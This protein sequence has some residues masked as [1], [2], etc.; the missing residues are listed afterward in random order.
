[1]FQF[2]WFDFYPTY[3][4]DTRFSVYADCFCRQFLLFITS[5]RYPLCIVHRW[6][7]LLWKQFILFTQQ[8]YYA[9][10]PN[11]LL[12]LYSLYPEQWRRTTL[13]VSLTPY[14][15]YFLKI[16]SQTRYTWRVGVFLPCCAV[17]AVLLAWC[18]RVTLGVLWKRN[19][20]TDG[21]RD[22]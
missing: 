6:F 3:F 5:T 20:A 7:R 15:H 13:H 2:I 9:V 10:I 17:D 19:A 12:V 14:S 22:R 11:P 18:R 1:M 16:L 4:E 21:G 8:K